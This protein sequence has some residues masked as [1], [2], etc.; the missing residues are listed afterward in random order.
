MY[1]RPKNLQ[2]AAK[3]LVNADSC[4]CDLIDGALAATADAGTPYPEAACHGA[5]TRQAGLIAGAF[6]FDLLDLFVV[7]RFDIVEQFVFLGHDNISL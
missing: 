1:S 7:V 3:R 2:I 4:G 6:E 5:A